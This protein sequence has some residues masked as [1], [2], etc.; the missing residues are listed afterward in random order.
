VTDQ[1]YRQVKK[2]LSPNYLSVALHVSVGPVGLLLGAD[3]VNCS[4]KDTS[5]GWDA[6]LENSNKN[7]QKCCLFKIPHHGSETGFHASVWDEMLSTNPIAIVTPYASS[8]LPKVDQVRQ[9]QAKT[10]EVHAT[11]WPPSKNPQK[12]RMY[13][14]IIAPATKSR[15]AP[16][17]NPGFVRIRFDLNESNPVGE[18]EHFCS[19][20]KL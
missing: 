17:T 20:T 18:I 5:F 10:T 6:V 1:P 12:R 7:G 16:P 11:S 13:D 2:S 9:L 4:P 14:G 19:A 3:L 15:K 8:S